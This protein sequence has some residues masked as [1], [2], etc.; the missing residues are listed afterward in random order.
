MRSQPLTHR[1]GRKQKA[2][3]ESHAALLLVGIVGMGRDANPY[4]GLGADLGTAAQQVRW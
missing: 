2:H 3:D 4:L 1:L